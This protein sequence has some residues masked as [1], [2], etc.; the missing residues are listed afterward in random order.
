MR[1]LTSESA[2]PYFIAVSNTLSV[3]P[4]I[5][6]EYSF[7]DSSSLWSD[8]RR[9]SA[10]ANNVSWLEWGV[11]ERRTVVLA[12]NCNSRGQL[13]FPTTITSALL[14]QIWTDQLV[15]SRLTGYRELVLVGAPIMIEQSLK[16]DHFAALSVLRPKEMTAPCLDLRAHVRCRRNTSAYALHSVSVHSGETRAIRALR[17]CPGPVFPL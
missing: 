4:P 12:E 15:G 2:T 8:E 5:N 10:Y 6:G 11:V 3:D 14:Y 9:D 13:Y 17:W 7:N 16:V 1:Q